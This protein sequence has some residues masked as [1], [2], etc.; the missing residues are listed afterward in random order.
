[1]CFFGRKSNQAVLLEKRSISWVVQTGSFAGGKKHFL[2]AGSSAGRM[3][4]S[5][6]DPLKRPFLAEHF[7]GEV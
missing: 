4:I 5:W 2:R 6:G 3:S 7:F 1:M